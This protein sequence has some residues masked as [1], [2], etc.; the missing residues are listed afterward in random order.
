MKTGADTNKIK[1]ALAMATVKEAGWI[2]DEDGEE[3]FRMTVV[4]KKEE[5]LPDFPISVVWQRTPVK[6]I[7]SD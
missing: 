4:Y 6:V 5:E 1:G 2:F 3:I 7:L